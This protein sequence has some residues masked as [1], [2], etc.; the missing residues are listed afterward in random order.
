L[1]LSDLVRKIAL[2]LDV[3]FRGWKKL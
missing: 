1:T 2:T 3:L